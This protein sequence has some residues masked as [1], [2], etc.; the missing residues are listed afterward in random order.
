VKTS[1]VIPAT[2]SLPTAGA[3][4]SAL[5]QPEGAKVRSVSITLNRD[6]LTGN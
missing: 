1:G 6:E 2:L 3:R 5:L 4:Q